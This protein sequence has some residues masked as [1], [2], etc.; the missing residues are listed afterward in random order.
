[1]IILYSIDNLPK[2]LSNKINNS[3]LY[4][5]NMPKGA[6]GIPILVTSTKYQPKKLYKWSIESSWKCFI[7]SYSVGVSGFC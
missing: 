6:K 1:M 7:K 5:P 4:V 3:S 2:L